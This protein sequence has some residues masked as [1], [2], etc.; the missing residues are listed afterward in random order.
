MSRE[1]GGRG[2]TWPLVAKKP[3]ELRRKQAGRAN[4]VPWNQLPSPFQRYSGA[5]PRPCRRRSCH[6]R[7]EPGDTH[8][9]FRVASLAWPGD[10]G[11]TWPEVRTKSVSWG[12]WRA[13][14]QE[15]S[16]WAHPVLA[17]EPPLRMFFQLSLC[18]GKLLSTHCSEPLHPTCPRPPVP[19]SHT[20]PGQETATPALSA[21]SGIPAS[22]WSQQARTRFSVHAASPSPI[23]NPHLSLSHNFGLCVHGGRKMGGRV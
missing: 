18:W 7:N 6:A 9:A 23:E 22:G 11:R 19:R 2:S 5:P 16:V 3:E 20:C 4:T 8:L 15:G 12:R 17:T 1:E 14:G 21:P 13:G 10:S